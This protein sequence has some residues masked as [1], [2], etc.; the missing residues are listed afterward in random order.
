M[1]T[2]G[3]LAAAL[4]SSLVTGCADEIPGAS[5]PEDQVYFPTALLAQPEHLLVVSSNFDQRY[6]A[7]RLHAF[8]MAQVLSRVP[9][10]GAPVAFVE[11][12][13]DAGEAGVPGLRVDQFGSQLKLTEFEGVQRIL[14]PTRGRNRL[15]MIDYM[16]GSGAVLDCGVAP[17]GPTRFDCR[18]RYV[19]TQ[20]Q[21]PFSV[22]VVPGLA[23]PTAFVTHLRSE[24]DD[25]EIYLQSLTRVDLQGLATY[26][27]EQEDAAPPVQT[28]EFT[29]L[30]GVTGAAYVP[31]DRLGVPS[32][33]SLFQGNVV[34]VERNRTPT[35]TLRA[36]GVGVSG[37]AAFLE[38][39]L[40]FPLGT[41]T[42]AIA[43]RGM[44]FDEAS[45]R[46][47][48]S[49]RFQETGDSFNAAIA[50]VDVS[51][52][53]FELLSLTEVGEELGEPVRYQAPGGGPSLLYVPDIRRNVIWVLDVS[54]DAP[55]VVHTIEGLGE[56]EL[57][58]VVE[59]VPLL[60]S[61]AGISFYD[62]GDRQLAFVSNFANSTIAVVDVSDPNPRAHRVVAR[63]G[64]NIDA[65]GEVERPND[66]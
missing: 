31:P 34:V 60:D 6:N 4:A 40:V 21:D 1:R 66:Q 32:T 25:N 5:P 36:F 13:V 42:S 14:L 65:E 45:D 17:E 43:S 61:P 64:R 12:I 16:A 9:A 30:G 56:R 38:E 11:T 41:L 33:V 39:R 58:G 10:P 22:V 44:V 35:L 63:L 50:T 59:Q 47:Y 8:D 26:Q 3:V 55:T 62:A 52:D 7:G 37:G 29:D 23:T 20:A 49:L 57:E 18:D 54:T 24:R 27:P 48:V 46:L 53:D 51:G 2:F 28:F 15:A 19:N